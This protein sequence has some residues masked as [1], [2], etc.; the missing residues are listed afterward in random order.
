MTG[1]VE[2]V[3][4]VKLFSSHSRYKY[5]TPSC[6][7]VLCYPLLDESHYWLYSSTPSFTHLW[8]QSYHSFIRFQFSYRFLASLKKY[9]NTGFQSFS[10]KIKTPQMNGLSSRY[11]IF[12]DSPRNTSGRGNLT[13]VSPH[14]TRC[15]HCECSEIFGRRI[16]S[17]ITDLRVLQQIVN[18][19]IESIGIN[20]LT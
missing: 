14:K 10:A 15:M 3:H 11:Q 2:G 5:I 19:S 12:A 4:L 18:V 13:S 8:H 16:K 9:A 6:Q 17:S 7:S 20:L 1:P